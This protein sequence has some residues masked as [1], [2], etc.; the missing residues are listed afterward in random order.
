LPIL[1]T[2]PVALTLLSLALMAGCGSEETTG[3]VDDSLRIATLVA[4]DSTLGPGDSTLVR[5]RIVESDGETPA[6]GREVQFGEMLDKTSGSYSKA[7]ALTDAN[8]EARTVFRNDT[9]SEAG[10]VYLKAT[11]GG[12]TAYTT[13]TLVT[14]PSNAAT[15]ELASLTGATAIP[16]DGMSALTVRLTITRGSEHTPVSGVQ[17]VIVAGDRFFDRDGNGVFNTGDDLL[18]DANDNGQWD[19]FG[20]APASARTNASGTAE[21]ILRSA[22]TTGTTFLRATAEGTYTELPIQFHSTSMQVEFTG[23]TP[24]QLFA[25]GVSDAQ[26]SARVVDADGVGVPGIIVRFAAGE[27]FVDEGVD[28]E[29]T[30]NVDAFT[31]WN[32]NGRWD[33]I[34]RIDSYAF[35]GSNGEV[36]A[37]YKAGLTVGEVRLRATATGGYSEY[38]VNLLPVPSAAVVNVTMDDDAVYADGRSEITGEVQAFDLNSTAL[39]GK[40]V[41]LVAGEPFDDVNNDGTFTDGTDVLLQDYD[42]NGTWTAIGT[43]DPN[44]AVTGEGGIAIFTYT[45]GTLE[46]PVTIKATADY[47]STDIEILLT[48]LPPAATVTLTA[49]FPEITVRNGGGN[50]NVKVTAT[51]FDALN[52]TVPAGLIVTFEVSDGP[53]GGEAFTGAVDGVYETHTDDA[54][55]ATAVLLAGT[56][57]GPVQV[58]CTVGVVVRTAQ[59]GIAAGLANAAEVIPEDGFL[60][61]YNQTTVRAYVKDTHRNP[62]RDGT[63]VQWSVDEGLIVGDDGGATSLTRGGVASATYYSLGPSMGTDYLAEITAEVIGLTTAGHGQI[64]LNQT[65]P[66]PIHE[67]QLSTSHQRINV[68]RTG[69]AETA[70]ILARG[71]TDDGQA[72]GAGYPIEFWIDAGPRGGENVNGVDD[73]ERVAALTNQDGI[74]QVTLEAGTLPGPVSVCC[75]SGTASQICVQIQIVAGPPVR[76]DAHAEPDEIGSNETSVI[77]AALLDEY[78]N[79]VQDGVVVS[80]SV[81]EGMVVG[82]DG[83]GSSRTEDGIARATYYSLTPQQGGDGIGTITCTAEGGD[84]STVA[85][86]RIPLLETGLASLSLTASDRNLMVTGAGGIDEASLD[87][88]AR[89]PGGAIVTDPYPVSF[90]ILS[91]PEG[92]EALNGVVGGPVLIN[93]NGQGRAAVSFTTGT[94]A[95]LVRVAVRYGAIW[96]NTV[97][98]NV[99]P[100]P[101]E[102]VECWPGRSRVF[103]DDTTTVFVIV[104]DLHYNPVEDSSVVTFVCDEGRVNGD[105]YNGALFSYTVG[106]LAKGLYRSFEAQEGG[107]GWA[108]IT[109]AVQSGPECDTRIAIPSTAEVPAS[110]QL[111][112]VRSEIG[113]RGTGQVEQ[114]ELIATPLNAQNGILGPGVAVVFQILSSPGGGVLIEGDAQEVTAYTRDDGTAHAILTAGTVSGIVRVE[115]TAGVL[116]AQ[117]ATVAIVAGPP[118]HIECNA[119]ASAECEAEIVDGSVRAYV[120]D[121]HHNAVRNG[122]I[123][124]FSADAGLITGMSGLGS[125]ATVGGIAEARYYAPLASECPAWTE[126]TLTF[127]TENNLVCTVTVAKA[128]A[129]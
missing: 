45:A 63:V 70:T 90:E 39:A 29:F 118:A 84:L 125:E 54:G 106:G 46:G 101:A 16:A 7:A 128:V 17:A 92:G 52:N 80:F 83:P 6:V 51:V 21:F 81:D 5:A 114:T 40:Q 64:Q 82:E 99:K 87:V 34:G 56:L 9:G 10:P 94:S 35:S 89:T 102:S 19:A 12:A 67:M 96:S 113:V 65:P 79:P 55:Q 31:D 108:Q 123:V 28:G 104:R 13:V 111:Y 33:A 47:A 95:G 126:A 2:V 3:P 129:P 41:T 11:I 93:T 43:I 1:L 121:T 36:S 59:V 74:A 78:G 97:N 24:G 53:G 30:P 122:T 42:D 110:V 127:R 58:F 100:G 50:D 112:A 37:T 60:D 119:P 32:S 57:T 98:L 23:V 124:W 76:M 14:V 120:T 72:V 116:A 109:C 66:P 15:L 75:K 25:D 91:G 38:T 8:G 105:A 4:D 69:P 48:S 86:V 18:E 44:P 73:G 117:A 85:N 62:V 115:A 103:A 68:R 26:V 88:V 49:E 22:E 20:T 71:F 107:D 61:F 27:P 77:T